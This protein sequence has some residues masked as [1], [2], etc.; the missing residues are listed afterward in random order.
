MG[1][2]LEEGGVLSIEGFDVR[3]C[4]RWVYFSAWW[5]AITAR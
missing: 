5:I 3:S 1:R 4:I 2:R